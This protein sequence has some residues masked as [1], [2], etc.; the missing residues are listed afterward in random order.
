M[1]IRLNDAERRD[2]RISSDNL[3][4][5]ARLVRDLGAVIIESAIPLDLLAD[6]RRAFIE[7]APGNGRLNPKKLPY[8]D[9]VIIAN[10]YALA[11][12]QEVMGNKIALAGCQIQRADPGSGR[13]GGASRP[14]SHLFPELPFP[15][16]PSCMQVAFP[17]GD[18]TEEAGAG[19]IWPGSHL[20]VDQPPSDVKNINLRARNLPSV[21]TTMAEGSLMLSDLR[22]WHAGMPNETD[23]ATLTMGIRYVRAFHT[24]TRYALPDS[25]KSKLPQETRKTLRVLSSEGPPRE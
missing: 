19:R 16:P 22:L 12:L 7:D 8:C 2:G 11:V 6:I 21:R 18:W 1:R 24:L 14:A 10:P 5:A 15:L 9:P 20:I 4:E 25:V 13:E 3:E 23:H 17:A